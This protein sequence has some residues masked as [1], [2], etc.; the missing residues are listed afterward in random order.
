M[1]ETTHAQLC[2]Q[3]TC[4]KSTGSVNPRVNHAR[5]AGQRLH[6]NPQ[7]VCAHGRVI[8]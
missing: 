1:P 4:R 6:R 7:L 3:A 5:A 8:R 2:Q